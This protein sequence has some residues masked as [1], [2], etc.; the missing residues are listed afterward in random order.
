MVKYQVTGRD[1][2]PLCMRGCWHAHHG[3]Q[4][5]HQLGHRGDLIASSSLCAWTAAPKSGTLLVP[6]ERMSSASR[7]YS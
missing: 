1:R 2:I 3:R 7:E 6:L 4:A 5:R